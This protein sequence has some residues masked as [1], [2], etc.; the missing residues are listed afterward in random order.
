MVAN[1]K[2]DGEEGEEGRGE[3]GY[4]VAAAISGERD[5]THS[6]IHTIRHLNDHQRCE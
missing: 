5:H 2:E 3:E 6:Y 4:T 1:E